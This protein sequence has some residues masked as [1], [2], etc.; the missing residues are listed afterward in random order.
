[1]TATFMDYSIQIPLIFFPLFTNASLQT[2]WDTYS[3]TVSSLL[4]DTECV[5]LAWGQT[6]LQYKEAP[7]R[8]QRG[9]V[10]Y[11]TLITAEESRP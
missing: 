8:N 10:E 11:Y 3:C 9:D 5:G 6:Q 1:M 4:G 7:V 2:Q